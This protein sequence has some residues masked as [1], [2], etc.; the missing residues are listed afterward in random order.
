MKKAISVSQSRIAGQ[1]DSGNTPMR[2]R[3]LRIAG[4]VAWGLLAVLLVVLWV[5]SFWWQ[6]WCVWGIGGTTNFQAMSHRGKLQISASNFPVAR[7]KQGLTLQSVSANF[8]PMGSHLDIDFQTQPYLVAACVLPHWLLVLST[9][10]VAAVPWIH[11]RFSY[12]GTCQVTM[13][14]TC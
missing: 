10:A 8:Y 1:N 13:G 2:F 3:K 5:R 7:P 6:D 12:V 9:T 11:W 14:F 4:S